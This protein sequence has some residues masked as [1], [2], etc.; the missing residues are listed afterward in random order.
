MNA[1]NANAIGQRGSMNTRSSAGSQARSGVGTLPIIVDRGST[2]L[3][4]GRDAVVTT[5]G[6]PTATV[7]RPRSGSR[8]LAVLH[9]TR[10]GAPDH[11]PATVA[12]I[13]GI[14]TRI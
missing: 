11:C 2:V 14:A 6:N 5:K 7:Y 8:R 4:D 9:R 10:V 13:V 12:A 3:Q 1:H